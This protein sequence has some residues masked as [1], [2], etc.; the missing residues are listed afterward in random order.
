MGLAYYQ[1]STGG[2]TSSARK[3]N[4]WQYPNTS[5][6]EDE[7]ENGVLTALEDMC[8]QLVNFWSIDGYA[9]NMA[10]DYPYA[11]T[12][13]PDTAHSTFEDYLDGRN[14]P[15]GV[16]LLVATDL[17]G[18]EADAGNGTGNTSFSTWRT[19]VMGTKD[20]PQE[21][22]QNGMIQESLHPTIDS[23]L[24]NVYEMGDHGPNSNNGNTEHDFGKV[25]DEIGQPLSPM[26][27][28]YLEEHA[29]HGTCARYAERMGFTR[30]MTD[31]TKQAVSY[32]ANNET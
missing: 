6:A 3:L 14:P 16:H 25:F 19:G 9:I 26:A 1:Q 20:R 31:C 7:C 22:W 13:D 21:W 23:N 17:T 10:T 8:D 12:S 4:I 11:D 30:T 18:G 29:G 2:D 5:S 27:T 24:S 28:G 15:V 32:T